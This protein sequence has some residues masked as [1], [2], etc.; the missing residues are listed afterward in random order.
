MRHGGAIIL[1]WML[2]ALLC[3]QQTFT[4]PNKPITGSVLDQAGLLTP[5]TIGQI[6]YISDGAKRTVEAPIVVVTL[7]SLGSVGADNIEWYA[8]TLFNAWAIGN[9]RTNRGVLVLISR[10][11]R[12]ARIEMGAGW[13]YNRDRECQQIMDGWM[14]PNFKKS[15]FDEGTLRAVMALDQLVRTG[16]AP[17]PPM[18]AWFW[19]AIIVLG[20]FIFFLIL[21]LAKNGMNNWAGSFLRGFGR[22]IIDLLSSFGRGGGGSSSGLSSGGGFSGGGFSGGGFS[23]GGGASGSW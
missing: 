21:D 22:F 19:P 12:K 4:I 3:A 17:R 2:A 6:N 14:I 20:V 7:T 5:Q 10:D 16:K 11:D 18:P 23:G 8:T 13:G 15:D 9:R 1:V